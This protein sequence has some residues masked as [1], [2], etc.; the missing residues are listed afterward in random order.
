[1]C[2]R[3]SSDSDDEDANEAAEMNM[4]V[5]CSQLATIVAEYKHEDLEKSYQFIRAAD[6]FIRGACYPKYGLSPTLILT[7]S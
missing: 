2:I 5:T 1:M 7:R 4:A 3:D 6:S